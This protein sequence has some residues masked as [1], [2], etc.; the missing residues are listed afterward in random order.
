V[1]VLVTDAQGNHALAVA[2]SLGQQGIRV[3]LADSVRSAKG[4]FTRYC[5][6]RAIYPSPSD[7]V[8]RFRA[9][10]HRALET[11]KP[12]VLM[13]MT[14]RTILGLLADREAIESRVILPLPSSEAVRVAFD[15][16][17]TVRLAK[18]L[19]VP[20]PQ[21]LVLDDVRQLE[22][23]R[24][25]VSYPAVIK[26]KSSEVRTIDDRIVPSG[27]VEY[28]FGPDD[29]ERRYLSVHRRSPLPLIQEFI[30]GDGYGVSVLCQRG[31]LKALFAHR[32]LRMVRP[33]GSGSSLRESI[34][35][36]PSMVDAATR[37]LESLAWDGVAMVEFKLDPRDGTP[38]LMEINGRFW[39]SL[40][41]AIAAGVDFPSLLYRMATEG[42]VPEC[43]NYR[44]G[45][46]SRWLLADARHLLG[47]L[48]G[49]PEGWIGDFPSRR[50]TLRGFLTFV[51]RDLY[52][53]DLWL[54]DPAPFFAELVD[55]MCRQVPRSI[56]HRR[57]PVLEPRLPETNRLWRRFRH[58]LS[59]TG[60]QHA[61]E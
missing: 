25:Q 54:S 44:V 9:G 59:A 1:S 16:S 30:P 3:A 29:L 61:I 38:K 14:E 12:A 15:K 57:P 56:F 21:T 49:R 11:L 37:L 45:V 34:A 41:L 6:D 53:D 46:K 51:E 17:E 31:R 4:L 23:I 26:P 18:L 13:P 42:D 48:R 52:Y 39:N 7:S 43:F 8:S 32:R 22:Q 36:P 19:R 10:I 20:V 47:V 33:T 27:A 24:S 60:G 40:P 50:E 35:P 58:R 5:A 28:C 2:R 55:V